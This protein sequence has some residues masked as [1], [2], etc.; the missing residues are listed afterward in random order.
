MCLCLYFPESVLQKTQIPFLFFSL[1]RRFYPP[2]FFQVQ[3]TGII[4]VVTQIPVQISPFKDAFY[5]DPMKR[6][7][8]CHPH[9][10]HWFMTVKVFIITWNH[11]F[12]LSICLSPPPLPSLGQPMTV[13]M[14]HGKFSNISYWTNRVK[15]K[16]LQ[17]F[18]DLWIFKKGGGK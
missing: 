14:A 10:S 5:D 12:S 6:G 11:H 9:H 4:P 18:S 7:L 2:R 16:F 17:D 15:D 8:T 1:P 3:F 13:S